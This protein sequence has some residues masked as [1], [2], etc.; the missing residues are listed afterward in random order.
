MTDLATVRLIISDTG[1]GDDQ[2]FADGDILAFLAL[3]GDNVKLAAATALDAMASN[4][5]LVSKRIRTLDLQTDGPA[6]SK[7]LRAHATALRKQYADALDSDE[8]GAFEMTTLMG[9]PD[10]SA[11]IT[12]PWPFV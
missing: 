8:G 5:V 9:T 3:E 10:A 1:T 11:L 7:E 2:V 4:E 12:R 6:V